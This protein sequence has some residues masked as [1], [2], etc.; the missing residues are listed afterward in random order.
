MD[1]LKNRG[2]ARAQVAHCP[3]LAGLPESARQVAAYGKL[4]PL[5]DALEISP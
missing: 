5:I 3:R 4:R 2:C 1:K